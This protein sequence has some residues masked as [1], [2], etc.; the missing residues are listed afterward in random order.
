VCGVASGITQIFGSVYGLVVAWMDQVEI[1]VLRVD[2]D[3]FWQY[4]YYVFK[5]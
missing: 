1:Q 4:L 3:V 2:P 5:F